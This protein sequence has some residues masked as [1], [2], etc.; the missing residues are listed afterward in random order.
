M[1]FE[2][3]Y[4]LAQCYEKSGEPSL[5]RAAYERS[6][7]LEPGNSHIYLKLASLCKHL[8]QG[9]EEKTFLR[10]CLELHPG[11]RNARAALK[12]C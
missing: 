3:F 10:K 11:N 5:A 7:D 4:W 8:G 2:S 12:N 1:M 9:E 6:L